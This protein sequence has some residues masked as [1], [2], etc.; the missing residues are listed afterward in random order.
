M[1]RTNIYLE[2]S[3]CDLLE[4]VAKLRG[5][6]VAEC[7]REAVSEWL[8]KREVKPFDRDEWRKRFDALLARRH[9]IAVDLGLTEEEV[10][11]EVWKAIRAVRKERR[12]RRR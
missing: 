7:V 5:V 11:R 4:G 2:E 3:Q 1:R 12:A 8:T 9:R 10:D 6:P